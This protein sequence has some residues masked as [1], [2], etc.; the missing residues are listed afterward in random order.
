MRHIVTNPAV[1]IRFGLPRLF[2]ELAVFDP[3]LSIW[4][5]RI[6]ERAQRYGHCGGSESQLHMAHELAA[7]TEKLAP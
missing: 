2:L 7:T 1:P 3:R 5:P 4:V 6:D